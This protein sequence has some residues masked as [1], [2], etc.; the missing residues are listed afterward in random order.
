MVRFQQRG[1]LAEPPDELVR[2]WDASAIRVGIAKRDYSIVAKSGRYFGH[3]CKSLRQDHQ[4]HVYSW[5]ASTSARTL[6]K[7]TST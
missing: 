4:Y 3:K 2:R 1:K 5:Y 7:G 6:A